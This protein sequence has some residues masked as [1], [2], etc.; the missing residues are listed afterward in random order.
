MTDPTGLSIGA[1]H[2]VAA[3][4]GAPPVTRRSV[5]T[6]F[7][8]RPPEVG[9]P[10]DN[11]VLAAAEPG[12]VLRGFVERVGDPIPLV[13]PDGSAHPADR[14]LA[15]A[16]ASMVGAVG[17][18]G[19]AVTLAVPSYWGPGVRRALENAVRADAR[20]SPGGVAPRL[21]PDATAA[22]TA[23]QTDPGL[24]GHGVIAVLDFGASGTS[25]TLFDA[26][27][28]F[29][30]LGETV[31]YPDFSGDQ[32]D[33]AV[34]AAVL[35]DLEARGDLDP[36]ATAAVGSLAT[37]RGEARRAKERLSAQTVT[38]LPLEL[39]EGAGRVEVRFTRA[40][41]D[42]LMVG[43]LG[44]VLDALQQLLDRGRI[45]WARIS[46]VATVG[47]GA[48]IPLVTQRLSQ[49]SQAPVLTT[50]WS[51]Q[52]GAIGAAL[53]SARGPDADAATGMSAA[54][55]SAA[56]G[57]APA[58]GE[59]D[60]ARNPAA[61]A[62][63]DGG[64]LA[65]SEAAD[66]VADPLPYQGGEI[67]FGSADFGAADFGSA[68]NPYRPDG[69]RPRVEYDDA[70]PIAAPR[71]RRSRLPGLA[72]AGAGLIALFAFGSVIYNLANDAKPI[73]SAPSVTEPVTTKAKLPPPPPEP[74]PV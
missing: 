7:R 2:L 32:I 17:G 15:A 53:L 62:G 36:A 60:T 68:E 48:A 28:G 44:G 25:M 26:D 63:T 61:G 59:P 64:G 12:L 42:A 34:L 20:L 74:S 9:T 6:L 52:G 5:L 13:A 54:T 38:T 24:P 51:G 35:A 30:Q 11:P 65:W 46:A 71:P 69:P 23:L 29:A 50:A 1:M 27:A 56:T 58:V 40:E 70:D 22:L 18:A 8:Q 73:E 33:A 57:L 21:V 19:G 37:L 3:R 45:P 39:P 16:L 4:V 41:L 43:G 31:R 49:L 67:D 14:L 66:A 55:A 10:A 47:G 72:V